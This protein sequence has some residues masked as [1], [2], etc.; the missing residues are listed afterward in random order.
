MQ[1]SR[2]YSMVYRICGPRNKWCGVLGAHYCLPARRL[3]SIRA[4]HDQT[5]GLDKRGE[6]T[7]IGNG[8]EI[9]GAVKKLPREWK[10]ATLRECKLHCFVGVI[11]ADAVSE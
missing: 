5:S 9:T 3:Q 7:S 2:I 1:V 6:V 11:P 8:H 4:C 10:M